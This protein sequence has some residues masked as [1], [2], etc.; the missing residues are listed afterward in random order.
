MHDL[1]NVPWTFWS[2]LQ[3][4]WLVLCTMNI[5]VKVAMCMTYIVYHEHLGHR[6]CMHDLYSVPWTFRSQMQQAWPIVCTMNIWVTVA[7]CMTYIVYHEDLGHSCCVHDLCSVPW[8]F[9]SHLLHAWPIVYTA[10]HEHFSQFLYHKHFNNSC[11]GITYTGVC[12][13]CSH[14]CWVCVLYTLP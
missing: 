11:C 13:P 7:V 3:H 12:E 14:S 5:W 8:I 9:Q 4:A 6:C 10:Y 2:Q 1:Y